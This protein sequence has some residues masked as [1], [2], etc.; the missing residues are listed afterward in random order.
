MWPNEPI[1][2]YVSFLPL[3]AHFLPGVHFQ[4]LFGKQSRH[5]NSVSLKYVRL[6]QIQPEREI[7]VM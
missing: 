7:L 6:L 3:G 5:N 2:S 1:I 4:V